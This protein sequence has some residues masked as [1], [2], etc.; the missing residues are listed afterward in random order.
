MDR[1]RWLVY[2]CLDMFILLLDRDSAWLPSEGEDIF[3]TIYLQSLTVLMLVTQEVI[4]VPRK[5]ANEARRSVAVVNV[6]NLEKM[7]AT[8]YA[9]ELVRVVA[10]M[11]EVSVFQLDTA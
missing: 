2:V 7:I 4:S 3:Q 9:I 11:E 10:F 6:V 8:I 1:S 5:D